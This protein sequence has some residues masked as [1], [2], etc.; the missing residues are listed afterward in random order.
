MISAA[1]ELSVDLLLLDSC[2]AGCSGLVKRE[3]DCARLLE[4]VFPSEEVLPAAGAGAEGVANNVSDC[5]RLDDELV[6]LLGLVCGGEVPGENS[7]FRFSRAGTTV[8]FCAS[9]MLAGVPGDRSIV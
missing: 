1:S 4:L 3:A 2:A 5:L 9:S 8:T 6:L 7:C